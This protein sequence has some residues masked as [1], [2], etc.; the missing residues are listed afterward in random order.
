MSRTSTAAERSSMTS[1]A[2][3]R[4]RSRTSTSRQRSTTSRVRTASVPTTTTSLMSCSSTNLGDLSEMTE[5]R[6]PGQTA[7]RR[8]SGVTLGDEADRVRHWSVRS[9]T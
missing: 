7:S 4:M 3:G 1:P 8:R 9:G 6:E 5:D 2:A